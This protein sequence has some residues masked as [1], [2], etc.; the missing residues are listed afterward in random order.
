V[1]DQP[2]G[3]A[4]QTQ[5]RQTALKPFEICVGS[6]DMAVRQ[7]LQKIFVGLNPLALNAEEIS[8][9]ELVLAEALNNIV[10]HAYPDALVQGAIHIRCRA[11]ADG[12][13]FTIIDQGNPMPNG[14]L[15]QGIPQNIDTELADLPEG[16]FGWCLINDLAKDV[17]YQRIGRENRLDLRI[18]VPICCEIK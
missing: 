3:S 14:Q 2:L 12:L 8:T 16:G 6:G 5:V 17:H 15:P 18:V 1:T 9:I 11:K 4:V 10:E 13:H 7:A